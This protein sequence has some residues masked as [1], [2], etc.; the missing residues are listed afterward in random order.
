MFICRR[1]PIKYLLSPY[2]GLGDTVAMRPPPPSEEEIL[3]PTKDKKRKRVS[4][5]SSPK[6]KKNKARKPR[7]DSMALSSEAIQHLRDDEEERENDDCLLVAR[8]RG[9]T[10]ASKA[11]EPVVADVVQSRTEEISKGS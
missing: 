4:P 11:A 8:K 5:G 9:S 7:A 10:E 3:K 2:A 6:P 1:F